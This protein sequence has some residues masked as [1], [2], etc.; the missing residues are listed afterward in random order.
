M[1]RAASVAVVCLLLSVTASSQYKDRFFDSAGVKIRYIVAGSGEPVILI[2]GFTADAE[3]NWGPVVKDLARDH[4]V[5]AMDC[6][7]H[8][9]S[10]KPH[11]ASQYG[12][13]MTADVVRLMDHLKI[14][15]AHIAGYSMGGFITL[16]LL[17][18]HPERFLTAILGGSGGMRADFPFAVLEPMIK[19]LEGG[20]S[21]AEVIGTS[22]P[23]AP[24]PEQAEFLKRISEI[25]DPKALAAAARSW[26]DLVVTDDQLRAIKVRTLAIYGSKDAAS[27]ITSLKGLISN[28]EFTVVDGADHL[29]APTRPEFVSGIRAF[30]EQHRGM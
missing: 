17:T 21:V 18:E 6:R 9:K 2:H 1:K 14:R 23:S 11:D 4:L 29:G 3:L 15:R 8:G 10:D 28:I 25:N 5:I 22:V 19:K 7:G 12:T 24:S 26:K 27:M 20:M 30:I 13:Q 16:K